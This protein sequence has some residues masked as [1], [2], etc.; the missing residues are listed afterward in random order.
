VDVK[1]INPF[2]LGVQAVFKTMLSI[3]ASM[4]KP[5]LKNKASSTGD[6]TG[7]LGFAGDKKGSFSISFRTNG[8]LFVYKQLIGEES[9]TV[10]EHVVDAIGE[11]TNIISGQARKEFEKQ[12][13]TLNASIP[14]VVVGKDV[15]I[16]FITK[17]PIVELPFKFPLDNGEMGELFLNFSFEG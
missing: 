13:L 14:M 10:N 7:T 1:F 16:N 17:P 2:I 4:E 11:L 3:D 5:Y 12:G 9:A 15:E 6:V 8:A